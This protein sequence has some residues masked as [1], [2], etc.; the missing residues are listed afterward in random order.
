[1]GAPYNPPPP[2]PTPFLAILHSFALYTC[3]YPYCLICLFNELLYNILQVCFFWPQLQM[4]LSISV[5]IL[6]S[7]PQHL[8]LLLSL[9]SRTQLVFCS[10]LGRRWRSKRRLRDGEWSEKGGVGGGMGG[11]GG[12]RLS[13]CGAGRSVRC[14]ATSDH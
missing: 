6:S 5:Q 4:Y 7:P 9:L 1:M 14:S 3:L 11:G 10:E 8:M 12:G 13:E 2:T